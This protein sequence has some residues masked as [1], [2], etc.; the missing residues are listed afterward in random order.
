[1]QPHSQ[2]FQ[3]S[4]EFR[5]SGGVFTDARQT[6]ALYREE[7]TTLS[8]ADLQ[9]QEETSGTMIGLLQR[10]ELAKSNDF[11]RLEYVQLEEQDGK[12]LGYEQQENFG[13]EQRDE[14]R[15]RQELDGEEKFGENREEFG[16]AGNDFEPPDE[17]HGLE[18]FE[19]REVIRET[20]E[21]FGEDGGERFNQDFELGRKDIGQSE[22][23]QKTR[24]FGEFG[25]LD[26]HQEE[27]EQQTRAHFTDGGSRFG[28][29]AGQGG[30]PMKE[31]SQKFNEMGQIFGETL[32]EK[33]KQ[34]ESDAFGQGVREEKVDK[35]EDDDDLKEP[36]TR[37]ERNEE[38]LREV[39]E[40]V[41]EPD[42]SFRSPQQGIRE[43]PRENV[44]DCSILTE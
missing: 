25:Q 12:R 17:L 7:D 13:A 43:E 19:A 24:R 14:F 41:V 23:Y 18:Q 42:E 6:S 32:F 39:E 16:E 11:D 2:D 21:H 3:G 36:K 33:S 26:A 34:P 9:Q 8:D 5:C 1:M 4:L 31:P 10:S 27:K 15:A 20:R 29:G 22:S 40:M 37:S 30:V 44:G 38:A 35:A 28:T